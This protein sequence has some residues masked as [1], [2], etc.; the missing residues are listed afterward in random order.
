M[1]GNATVAGQQ[2]LAAAANRWLKEY[3]HLAGWLEAIG[4]VIALLFGAIQLREARIA[5][6]S[7]AEANRIALKSEASDLLVGINAAA[8]DHPEVAGEY[9]GPRRLH[10]MRLH[11]FFRVFELHE[12]GIFD[13][14]RFSAETRYLRWT[15]KQPEF[16]LVWNE[17]AE[18]YPTRFRGWVDGMV[19]SAT[20]ESAG[21]EPD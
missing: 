3:Q 2:R 11:Y 12:Q 16:R 1:Q 14:D 20:R 13:D 19:I 9:A 6:E 17:F 4:V 10:L 8:L 15:I 7:A 21:D 5:L 18:Q